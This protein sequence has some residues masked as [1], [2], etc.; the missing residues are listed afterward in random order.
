LKFRSGFVTNSSS[1]SFI[2][3]AKIDKSDEFIKYFKEEYGKYGIG[4]LDEYLVS[5]EQIKADDN[6]NYEELKDYC[7]ENGIEL[8]DKDLYLQ[9]RFIA[10]TTEGDSEEDD[11]W[12]YE[13]IPTQY[14]E[15]IYE[16]EVE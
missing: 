9:A 13:H 1:S 2:C 4:L 3:V 10:W 14:K 12:L 16:G 8:K 15:E 11:A 6:Y 7:R 5:G